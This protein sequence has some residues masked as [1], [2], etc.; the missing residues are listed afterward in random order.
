LTSPA[1]KDL[2]GVDVDPIRL[3]DGRWTFVPMV[4]AHRTASKATA[5]IA[6]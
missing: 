1:L 4:A 2:Y 6:R 3:P 5:E